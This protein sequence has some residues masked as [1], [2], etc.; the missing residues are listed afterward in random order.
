MR[1]NECESFAHAKAHHFARANDE[2]FCAVPN[3]AYNVEFCVVQ[4]TATLS[5]GFQAGQKC[6][7]VHYI[8]R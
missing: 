7:S 6:P 3:L 1:N 8:N 5:A 2:F 4:S